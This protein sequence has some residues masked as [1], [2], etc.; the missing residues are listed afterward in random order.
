MEVHSVKHIDQKGE[1]KNM[2]KDALQ[3]LNEVRKV[4]VGKDLVIAKVFMAI[5]SKGH[6]L[7]ED[8]PGVGKTTLALSFSKVLGLDY[9]RIQFTSDSVPSVLLGFSIYDKKMEISNIKQV[10]P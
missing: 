9:R 1:S 5:L 3:I 4:I 8:V 7:L 6:V 10:L 2:Q